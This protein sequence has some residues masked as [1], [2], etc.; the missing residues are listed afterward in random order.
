MNPDSSEQTRWFAAEVLPHE[1][2]LRAYLRRAFPSI[3]DVDDLVQET[4][5]R[6]FRARNAG[7][8]T[9]ARPYLFSIARNAACDAFRRSKIISITGVAD[10]D[11]SSVVE[12]RPAIGE[13]VAHAQELEMLR[14]A[15]QALPERCRQ[16]FTLCKLQGLP[17]REVARRLG[18]SEH[19][20]NAQIALGVLRCRDFLRARGLLEKDRA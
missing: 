18:I 9:E 6:V 11:D 20:V 10:F 17:H 7:K 19:T 4:Y 12:D 13:A 2:D 16:V 8:V 15:I 5:A 14:D 1:P 3:R